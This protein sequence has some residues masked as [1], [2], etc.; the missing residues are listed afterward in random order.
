MTLYITD[1]N[2]FI[3]RH[4][5]DLLDLVADRGLAIATSSLVFD[6]LNQQQQASIT[7]LTDRKSIAIQDVSLAEIKALALPK[8]L[9]LPDQSAIC[10]VLREQGILLSGDGLLRRTASKLKVE[11]HGLLW[12]FDL[13]VEANLLLPHLA[14]EKLIWLVEEKGSRQPEEECR[15]RLEKWKNK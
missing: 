10:L 4:H 14:A 1:A 12:L 13:F 5:A 3:D 8:G 9:S 7:R 11:T 6:E 15:A 2:I